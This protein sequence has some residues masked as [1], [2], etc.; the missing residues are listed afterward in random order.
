MYGWARAGWKRKAGALENLELWQQLYESAKR[1]E[2]EWKWVRGHAGHPQNEYA[3]H[4][5][6]RAAKEQTHS[7]GLVESAFAEWLAQQR[8]KYDK[9]LMFDETA[10]VERASE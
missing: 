3:N 6:T 1:H 2:I 4:L 5:A 9:Y 10:A 7:N 8:E